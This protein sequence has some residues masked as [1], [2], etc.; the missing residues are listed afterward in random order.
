MSSILISSAQLRRA[1]AVKQKIES[2][3]GRLAKLLGGSYNGNGFA[4]K[5]R[6][7]SMSPAAKARIIAAQK[8]RWAKWRKEHGR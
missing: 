4:A 3:E 2:L 1:I 6:R 7:N 8:K 5:S